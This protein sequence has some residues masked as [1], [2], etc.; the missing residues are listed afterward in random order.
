MPTSA[1]SRSAEITALLRDEILRGQYRRGERLPSERDLA[2][3]FDVHRSAV[4]EALKRLETLGLADIQ[5]GGARVAPIEQASL[6]VVEHL[7]DLEDPPNPET[8]R[9]VL[10]VLSGLFSISARYAAERASDE[11]R[12]AIGELLAKLELTESPDED[13]VLMRQLGDQFV[14]ASGNLIL[15]MVRRGVH[16]RF[17]DRLEPLGLPS[18]PHSSNRAARIRDLARAI[19]TRDGPAA[20]E[21]I[22]EMS[23]VMREH[24]LV[25]IEAE[26]ARQ[27]VRSNTS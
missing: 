9:E 7:L 24:A 22:Y 23:V 8:V 6:D 10:E 11:Q 16:T 26:R 1:T 19:K 15:K 25:V 27:A 20:S 17:F 4:R 5:P 13:V 21:A 2:E 18:E 12:E 14:E 3:R